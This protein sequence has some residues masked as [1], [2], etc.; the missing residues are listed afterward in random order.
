V[1]TQTYFSLEIQVGLLILTVVGLS[2]EYIVSIC[3]GYTEDL[4]YKHRYNHFGYDT[5]S[6]R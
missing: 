3:S 2:T 6:S 4:S 1:Y 5:I